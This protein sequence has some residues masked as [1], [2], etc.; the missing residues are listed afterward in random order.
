MKYF[1]QSND[2]TM[3]T[4]VEGSRQKTNGIYPQQHSVMIDCGLQFIMLYK[5]QQIQ[6]NY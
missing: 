5:K 2:K 3:M 1:L 4:R 6:S